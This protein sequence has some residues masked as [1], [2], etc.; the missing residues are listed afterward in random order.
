M[1]FQGQVVLW[2]LILQILLEI[3][4]HDRVAFLKLPKP[5]ELVLQTLVGQVDRGVLLLQVVLGGGCAQVAFLK[6]VNFVVVGNSGPNSYV[7]LAGFVQKRLLDVLLH[8]PE[9]LLL[10]LLENELGYVAQ[11]RENFDAPALIQRCRLNDPHILLAVL[12]WHSLV[13]GPA[14][15]QLTEPVHEVLDL[16]IVLRPGNRV[17]GW[18]G[19]KE[20]VVLRFCL[21]QRLVVAL[22]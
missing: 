22:Q 11:L 15:D 1:L 16:A 21:F 18:R 20:R 2:E 5:F 9:G 4:K 7:E 13:F 19:I 8:N 17:G 14:V 3:R 12:H 10:V 6:N